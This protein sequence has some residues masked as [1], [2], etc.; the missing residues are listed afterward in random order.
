M[1]GRT[2]QGRG[3]NV[4]RRYGIKF[5]VKSPTGPITTEKWY[6]NQSDRNREHAALVSQFGDRL[7]W[8]KKLNR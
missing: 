7:I 8:S 6:E 4:P 5:K 1:A 3:R 2:G